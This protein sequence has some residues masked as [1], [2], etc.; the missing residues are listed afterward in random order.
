M[1]ALVWGQLKI[2]K[3]E[4]D[5]RD[6]LIGTWKLVSTEETLNDGSSRPFSGYGPDA[7]G[8]LIYQ[9]DGYMCALLEKLAGAFAYCGRYEID[10]EQGQIVH[11]PAV[12]TDP[13]FVG[14]RQVRPFV[15]EGDRL[16]FSDFEKQD[17]SV[18][19]WKIVWEKAR[20]APEAER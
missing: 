1:P 13:E 2:M 6:R 12:A 15:F 8:F 7:Q 9:R 16:I 17:P 18:S 10:E 3:S 5:I 19:R 4:L 14:S 20:Q 11:L